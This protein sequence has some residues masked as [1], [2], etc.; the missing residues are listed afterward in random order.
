MTVFGLHCINRIELIPF[1]NIKLDQVYIPFFHRIEY[2]L[3][4]PRPF[5]ENFFKVIP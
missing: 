3:V 5:S 1:L 2:I 4:F